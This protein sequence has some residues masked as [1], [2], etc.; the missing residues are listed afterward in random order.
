MNDLTTFL[1]ARLGE[2]KQWAQDLI[3]HGPAD[4]SGMLGI[5]Q[6]MLREVT[7]KRALIERYE[8]AARIPASV[9]GYV[10]GQDD[11]YREAC[12]DALRDAAAV[13]DSHPGY[14]SEWSE[15]DQ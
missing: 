1:A 11:G 8:R 14:R 13:Y 2:D 9:A 3:A 10:R 5:A 15:N 7:A 12:L 4:I 6:R